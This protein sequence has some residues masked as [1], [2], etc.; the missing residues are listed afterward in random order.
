M[1]SGDLNLA[2]GVEVVEG[3]LETRRHGLL[4]LANPHPWVVVFLVGLVIAYCC[5]SKNQKIGMNTKLTLRVSDLG[6]QVVLL[7]LY[8]IPDTRQVSP[9]HVSVKVDLDDSVGDLQVLV[10]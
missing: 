3:G 8:V 2:S 6:L 5:Q 1:F 10:C 4:T 9:L 7:R